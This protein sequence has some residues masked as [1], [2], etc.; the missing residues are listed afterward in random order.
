MKKMISTLVL[1]PFLVAAGRAVRPAAPVHGEAVLKSALSSVEAGG[2][3]PV[4]GREF[5]KGETVTL[6][7][8]GVFDEFDLPPARPDSSGA[9]ELSLEIPADVPPGRYQLAAFAPD[10]DELARLAVT[11]EAAT[12]S[13]GAADHGAAEAPPDEMGRMHEDASARA[14]DMPIERSRSGLEWGIIGLLIGLSGGAG[15]VLLLRS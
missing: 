6:R 15:A 10:G 4:T 13:S 11:V 7:L 14:D 3:L 1:I 8:L 5:P 12:G 2:T 9:F